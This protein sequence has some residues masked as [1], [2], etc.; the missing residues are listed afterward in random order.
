MGFG[1]ILGNKGACAIK[2]SIGV[3]NISFICTHLHSGQ[4]QKKLAQRNKDLR[5]I[6]RR[7]VDAK[8]KKKAKD[9]QITP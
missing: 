3:T 5:A 8:N 1:G 4:S 7:F 6:N 9:S 2:L